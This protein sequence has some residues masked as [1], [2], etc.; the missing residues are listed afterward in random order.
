M[1]N[2]LFIA[3]IAILALVIFGLIWA[4]LVATPKTKQFRTYENTSTIG[5]M[6]NRAWDAAVARARN[7][8]Q[9]SL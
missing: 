9:G 7:H 6:R 4:W 1:F 8:H 3:G 2:F 5:S